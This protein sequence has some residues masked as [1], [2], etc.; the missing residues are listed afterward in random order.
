MLM[1]PCSYNSCCL[2]KSESEESSDNVLPGLCWLTTIIK[3][4]RGIFK[5]LLQ[6]VTNSAGICRQM[7]ETKQCNNYV[8]SHYFLVFFHLLS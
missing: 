4:T 6:N 1:V 2:S 5:N 7:L 8:R 3:Q